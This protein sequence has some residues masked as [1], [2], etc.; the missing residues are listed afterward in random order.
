MREIKFRAWDNVNNKMF[1]DCFSLKSHGSTIW[2]KFEKEA[3]EDLMWMQFTGLKDKNGKEIYE[4]DI[5]QQLFPNFE[6][7]ELDNPKVARW[8]NKISEIEYRNHGFWVKDEDFG[9]EGESLWNWTNLEIVGNIYENPEFL[10]T[11]TDT[12]DCHKRKGR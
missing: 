6:W 11:V 8:V 5:V 12:D 4:G 10:K 2:N 1:N 9:W 3:S 7:D